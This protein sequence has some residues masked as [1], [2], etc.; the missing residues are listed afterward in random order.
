LEDKCLSN[1]KLNE[2]IVC[3]LLGSILFSLVENLVA[4]TADSGPIV[5]ESSHQTTTKP[6]GVLSAGPDTTDNWIYTLDYTN[7]SKETLPIQ[8]DLY[9]PTNNSFQTGTLGTINY[10]DKGRNIIQQDILFER[11]I[12]WKYNLQISNY[13]NELFSFNFGIHF[14][15]RLTLDYPTEMIENRSFPVYATITPL[16]WPNYNE[17]TCYFNYFGSSIFNASQSFKTPLGQENAWIPFTIPIP[18]W[19]LKILNAATLGVNIDISPQVFSTKIDAFIQITSPGIINTST[20]LEWNSADQRVRFDISFNNAS[21]SAVTS[22]MLTE[23]KLYLNNLD[24][25]FDLHFFLDSFMGSCNWIVHLFTIDVSSFVPTLPYIPST[26]PQMPIKV[27]ISFLKQSNNSGYTS[28]E[29][30]LWQIADPGDKIISLKVTDDLNNDG[31]QDL[32]I[33]A[34]KS[35]TTC[36]A[37]INGKNGAT[38]RQLTIPLDPK[39]SLIISKPTIYIA[40]AYPSE[41]RIYDQNLQLSRRFVTTDI[42]SH[43]QTFSGK[44]ILFY[45]NTGGTWGSWT[46]YCYSLTNSALL[47]SHQISGALGLSRT[48]KDILVLNSNLLVAIVT[49]DE[50]FSHFWYAD[51][52]SSTGDGTTAIGLAN[53]NS[54][55][56]LNLSFYDTTHFLYSIQT[57]SSKVLRL[58]QIVGSSEKIIWNVTI[59]NTPG[60][61]GFPT[62]DITNDGI[63]EVAVMNNSRL[64][65]LNGNSGKPTYYIPEIYQDNITSIIPLSDIDGDGINELSIGTENLY[66][67]SL[68]TASYSII[69]QQYMNVV[70]SDTIK[71]ISGD[72]FPDII[73]ANNINICS[74][75]Q[76]QIDVRPPVAEA[77]PNQTVLTNVPLNLDGSSSSDNMQIANYVWSFTDGTLQRIEGAK[78]W[79]TFKTAGSY[80]IT[81]N[82]TDTYGNWNTNTTTITVLDSSPTITPKPTP[83]PTSTSMLSPTPTLTPTPI[84]PE[85]QPSAILAIMILSLSLAIATRKNKK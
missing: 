31:F 30:K 54:Q 34:S 9:N 80:L 76:G 17:F 16:D 83:T 79:Y 7:G 13:E 53:T 3:I 50:L 57:G 60:N 36:I 4:V 39:E 20:D 45:Y 15:V 71:D 24:L 48:L 69:S 33:L 44:E 55:D 25:S 5:T 64:V 19:Q 41:V 1:K 56:I 21:I 78:T 35:N 14:P 27:N 49:Q 51:L 66:F 59:Q 46:I 52:F 73:V 74:F 18:L 68:K 40:V 67:V 43:L 23:F 81:L 26:W 22:L 38:I 28:M 47:W 84:T 70:Y 42:P 32:I 77:G 8:G 75:I 29:D 62:V 37:I 85:F 10:T 58:S 2:I 65:L 82:V 72:Q 61:E 6:P 11:E 12:K 63:K